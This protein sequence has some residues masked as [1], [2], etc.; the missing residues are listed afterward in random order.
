MSRKVPQSDRARAAGVK[1]ST[2]PATPADD[3]A[4]KVERVLA[5][6]ESGE[7]VRAA[8]QAE[9]VDPRRVYEWRDLSPAN[10][11]RYAR[12][13]E[14]QADAIVEGTFD[15]ADDSARDTLVDQHGNTRPDKEWIA[16][17]RLRVDTRKWYASKIAP[18]LYGDKLDV[19]TDGKEF[20]A[21]VV[22]IERDA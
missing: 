8:C 1:P 11:Q 9:E 20:P 17:S 21:F 16:R 18:R 5:R 22:R 13:R 3:T 6:I 7:L 4:E 10:A 15:I 19:T 12:A 14:R 2:R